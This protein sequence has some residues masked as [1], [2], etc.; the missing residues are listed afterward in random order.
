MELCKKI[1]KDEYEF[2][3]VRIERPDHVS[4]L[5]PEQL[6]DVSETQLDDYDFDYRVV[7]DGT[8][9]E[10]GDKLSEILMPYIE[11]IC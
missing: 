11:A 1:L 2:V 9:D 4:K 5:T 3:L 6:A 8:I 10:L 7:N